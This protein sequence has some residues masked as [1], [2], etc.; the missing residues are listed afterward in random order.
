MKKVTEV[1][2]RFSFSVYRVIEVSENDV[3][4]AE[5]SPS[6]VNLL[7]GWLRSRISRISRLFRAKLRDVLSSFGAWFVDCL[8]QCLPR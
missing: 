6:L 5:E 4:L 2:I 3:D 7:G 8:I 1:K